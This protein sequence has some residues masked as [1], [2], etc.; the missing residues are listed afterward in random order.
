LEFHFDWSPA[1]NASKTLPGGRY[2]VLW[3]ME[4]VP[5]RNIVMALESRELFAKRFPPQSFFSI[6]DRFPQVFI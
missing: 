1:R 2:K 5:Q 3:E 6:P 4:N